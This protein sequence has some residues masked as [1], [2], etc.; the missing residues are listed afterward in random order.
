MVN[1]QKAWLPEHWVP[2]FTTGS[3]QQVALAVP[4]FANGVTFTG[5]QTVSF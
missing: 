5:T 2:D 4:G 1:E 3:P